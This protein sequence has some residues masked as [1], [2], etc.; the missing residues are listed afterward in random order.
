MSDLFGKSIYYM[1]KDINGFGLLGG[2]WLFRNNLR[3]AII[4]I[5]NKVQTITSC[6]TTGP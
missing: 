4:I 3:K 1:P 2:N 6:T 5:D